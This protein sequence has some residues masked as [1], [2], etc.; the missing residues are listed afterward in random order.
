M[1]AAFALLAT[2]VEMTED[3]K[4]HMLN[5][6]L[7][8]LRGPFPGPLTVPFYL[9]AR[10]IFPPEECGAAYEVEFRVFAPDGRQVGGE[11]MRIEAPPPAP[12]CV[13]KVTLVLGF[14]GFAFETLGTYL[15]R[16]MIGGRSLAEV[17][18]NVMRL[19]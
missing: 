11:T 10:L 9:A 19:E 18:F 12:N 2:A 1:E 13:T 4:L 6:G 3:G 7:D 15:I 5:A 8:S 17:P 14:A 16:I